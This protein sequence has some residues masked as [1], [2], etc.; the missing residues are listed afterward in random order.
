MHGAGVVE[1][2]HSQALARRSPRPAARA[3]RG[4]PPPFTSHAP[5]DCAAPGAVRGPGPLQLSKKL[6]QRLV[7]ARGAQ[8]L[9]PLH[10]EHG[11]SFNDVN[12]ATCWSRL[13]RAGCGE[14]LAWQLDALREQ[15]LATV[16]GWSARQLAN[17]AHALGKLEERVATH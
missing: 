13:G 1:R 14:G 3:D 4:H 9:L 5:Y 16:G 6:N 15:T 10:A 2:G 8:E 7:Q 11:G 12:L 17:L